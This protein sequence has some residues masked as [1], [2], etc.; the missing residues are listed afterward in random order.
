VETVR[1]EP[2]TSANWERCAAIA[3][4]PGQERYVAAVT[5]YLCLCLYGSTWRPVAIV[6]DD[7]VVG[8]YM[9]AVEDN[10]TVWVGGLVI[11][12]AAQRTGVARSTLSV[13]IGRCQ[14]DPGCPGL[15]LS[16]HPDNTAAKT[17]Y[18]SLGFRETGET[19]DGGAEVIARWTTPPPRI[20]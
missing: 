11:D 8:F 6:R 13:L 20:R 16:Y 14:A 1:L 19:L 7:A 3:V 5:Y 4:R 10:A 17:L 18:A 9:E 12:A 15:A 2:V